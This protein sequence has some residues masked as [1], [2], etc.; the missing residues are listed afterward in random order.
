MKME[1][2][3]DGKLKELDLGGLKGRYV[4]ELLDIGLKASE[5]KE[6]DS[7]IIKK[8]MSRQDEIAAEI[9]GLTVEQL[10]D[11]DVDDKAK[12]IGY[13]GDKTAN[14]MGFMKPSQK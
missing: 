4:N 6:V 12:I 14:V 9:S 3:L 10:N 2:V 7:A 8:L 13:I 5:G 11:L 1:V